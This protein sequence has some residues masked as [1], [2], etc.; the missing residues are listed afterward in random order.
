MSTIQ[1]YDI[2]KNRSR[3][4]VR[5]RDVNNKSTSKSGFLT[6]KAA[7]GFAA[8]LTTAKVSG[9]ELD[10]GAQKKSA[11]VYIE[12]HVA[13]TVDL[14]PATIANRKSV[15][16]NHVLPVWGGVTLTKV[17]RKRV[18]D[19]VEKMHQGGTGPDTIQKAHGILLASFA[20]AMD[21]RAI[22][23]N[24]ASGVRVPKSAKPTNTYLTHEEVVE[25]ADAIDPRSRTLVGLLS[26]SGLRFGEITALR[27]GKVNIEKRR[28]TVD[29]AA[30]AVD[31]VLVEGP[32]KFKKNRDVFFPELLLDAMQELVDG[33][34]KSDYLF[35]AALGGCVRLDDWR[36]RT[37]YKAI[38]NINVAR[39]AKSKLDGIAVDCFPEV[40][41]HDLRHTAASI[42]VSSG[43]NVK[44]LQKMLGHA[45]AA[46]TLDRYADLFDSDDVSVSNAI[47]A[48]ILERVGPE[49]W[50]VRSA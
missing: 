6:E 46:M 40:T 18:N 27:V 25:L 5:Y 35:T 29:R 42:A 9:S 33:K 38:E 22:G 2:A 8:A 19:W 49:V 23:S 12:Q 10:R 26:Y 17:T 44:V 30:T 34:L 4:R 50:S 14:S 43:A 48:Q 37:F 16:K 47:N 1:K 39:A 15:A 11:G 36:P 13:R 31:G 7:N 20:L 32:P 3:W 24:P 28:L 45:S 21:D 41:P